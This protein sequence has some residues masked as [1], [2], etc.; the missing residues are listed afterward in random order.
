MKNII[1]I[2]TSENLYGGNLYE[3]L[4]VQCLKEAGCQVQEYLSTPNTKYRFLRYMMFPIFF[5]RL[6]KI[7][8]MNSEYTVRA[9]ETS[10]F[11]SENSKNIII[12]HHYDLTYSNI[13]SKIIQYLAFQNLINNKSKIYKLI[14]VSKYWKNFFQEK[15][16][17]NIEIVYNCFNP[18]LYSRTKKEKE[19][20]KQKYN[21]PTDKIL[22][23]IGNP[24]IKKGTLEIY[25]LLKNNKD[26]Y[27][28]TSGTKEIDINT[29]HLSL[30]YYDYITLLSTV[31]IVILNSKFLEGWN[32]IA[33]ESLLAKTPVIGSGKG[34]MHELLNMGKQKIFSNIEEIPELIKEV[35]SNYSE[36][37]SNG[38]KN[39]K[40]FDCNI[41]CD[42]V[43]KV[44]ECAE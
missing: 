9:L 15:G 43:R 4:L 34:G 22:L 39:L 8:K 31:D 36:Y 12:A 10:F 40:Y 14:V 16:F 42:K 30:N 3:N 19:D 28:I 21:I 41:F 26:Y 11:L 29:C 25:E 37:S 5:Y 7:Q 23:Y 24:Q 38:Y 18:T 1:R 33:H 13:F 20:F 2:K 17:Q 35:L 32:R 27:L 6:K 44:F